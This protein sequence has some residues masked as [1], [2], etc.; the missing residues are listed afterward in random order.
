MFI[1]S[2][3]SFVGKIKLCF[4]MLIFQYDEKGCLDVTWKHLVMFKM[5]K[6]IDI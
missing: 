3:G 6:N 2:S 1:F 4:A 5:H